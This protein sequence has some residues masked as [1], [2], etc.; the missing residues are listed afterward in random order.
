M[1][2][3]VAAV[4]EVEEVVSTNIEEV[5]QRLVQCDLS[6]FLFS[7]KGDDDDGEKKGGFRQ[8]WGR[9]ERGKEMTHSQ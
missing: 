2:I 8:R 3:V 1:G 5:S 6:I 4:G 9:L 7:D